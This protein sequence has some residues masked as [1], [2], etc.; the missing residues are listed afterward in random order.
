MPRIGAV[1]E[2]VG[3][4]LV[5]VARLDGAQRRGE[6]LVVLGNLVVGRERAASEQPADER[7]DADREDDGGTG[8]GSVA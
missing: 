6:R 5:D 4:D 2:A 8:R 3:I 1:D 7:G